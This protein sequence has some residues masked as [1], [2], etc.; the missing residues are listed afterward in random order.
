MSDDFSSLKDINLDGRQTRDFEAHM[1]H[2]IDVCLG[3]H[4]FGQDYVVD[5]RE[6]VRLY[7]CVREQLT[8]RKHYDIFMVAQFQKDADVFMKRYKALTGR[9]GMT[10]YFHMLDAGHFAFFLHKYGNLYRLSQQGWENVNSIMK[11]SFHR[12]T[13]RGGCKRGTSKILP[14]F[15]RLHRAMM[16]RMGHLGIP[17]TVSAMTRYCRLVEIADCNVKLGMVMHCLYLVAWRDAVKDW[18]FDNHFNT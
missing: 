18:L 13:Q 16:W 8:S 1:D 17:S 15:L 10:N 5:W 7:S 9:D 6:T 11:R 2:L 4:T 14:V 3:D 12:N